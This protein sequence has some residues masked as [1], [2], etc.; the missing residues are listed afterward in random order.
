MQSDIAIPF[1]KWAGGK[2]WLISNHVEEIPT[3][4]NRYI[5]PFLGSA[6]VFFHLR[7]QNA[8]LS[9]LNSGLISTYLAVRDAPL[10]VREAL[11][12]HNRQHSVEYYYSVRE[13][14]PLKAHTKAAKFIYLNRT[15]WNGLYRVNMKGQFNV[16]KGT[17]ESVLLNTDDFPKLSKIL[18]NIDIR[19]SDFEAAI[20]EANDGDLVFVDP[21]YTINHNLNGF[22]KYNE[23]IFSW[24]DQIRLRD[25]LLRAKERG[26]TIIATNAAHSS[27]RSLYKDEFRLKALSRKSVIAAAS[28]SRGRFS[29]LLIKG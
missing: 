16:P 17:K 28:E 1:L 8:L 7:P 4:F 19:H 26:A 21:P 22:I 6:A 2:R 13:S 10:K 9:D 15:C 11:V 23:K 24:D 25:S 3:S 29:E 12:R 27:I 20:D 14:S 18:Q 5:E